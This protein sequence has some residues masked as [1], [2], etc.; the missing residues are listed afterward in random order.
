MVLFQGRNGQGKS[1]LLEALYILA[2]AKSPRVSS[3]RE[4]IRQPAAP[5]DAYAQVSATVR[6]G[7]EDLRLQIDYQALP[8]DAA[9]SAE[10]ASATTVRRH[11]RV[12]GVPRRASE[13][14]GQ[15][16]AVMFSAEDLAL[17]YGSPTVRRRYLDILIS[18]LDREYLR[19][20][21]RYQ[22][23]VY[24]RNHLLRM[25]REGRSSAEELAFWNDELVREGSYI[26]SERSRTVRA[27]SDLASPAHQELTGGLE[28]LEITYAPSF[29]I[30][31]DGQVEA[32]ADAFRD[33]IETRGE[34]E[35]AQGATLSGPHRDDLQIRINGMEAGAFAS[36]GQSR[37]AV[38][39]MR[40]AEAGYLAQERASGPIV[41]L[42][43]VLSELDTS[44]RAHVLDR[45]ASYEQCLITATDLEHVDGRFLSRM[46]ILTIEDAG[47][48]PMIM[49]ATPGTAP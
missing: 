2:I 46:S 35:T 22:K 6:R 18:Q 28:R 41:L 13:L 47:I 5:E 49:A 24:Q 37:T 10:A 7:S 39:A 4:L 30:D 19:T 27:L 29:A 45:A 40:L 42:D 21:Q 14:V 16:T 31:E 15:M 20:L 12:N 23:V 8:G 9:K 36:R 26:V 33:S 32:I 3:D 43:D 25:V 1:N 34:R 48:R 38:L 44:R 11:I 17:V